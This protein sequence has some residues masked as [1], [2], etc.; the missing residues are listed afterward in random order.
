MD[1]DILRL[2]ASRDERGLELLRSQYDSLIRYFARGILLD[3]R[4]LE[5]CVSDVYLAVWEKAGTY[6]PAKGKLST[7]LAAISRNAAL[8]LQKRKKPDARPLDE[9]AAAPPDT[10]EGRLLDQEALRSLTSAING[11]PAADRRLF[12]RKYYF[13]QPTAQIAAELGTTARAIEG[14]LYRIRKRLQKKLGGDW[15]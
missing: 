3:A 6:D 15:Q 1:E 8:N 7:W 4:D 5:E 12:Y 14:R 2:L 13:L 9:S 11:L 10:P